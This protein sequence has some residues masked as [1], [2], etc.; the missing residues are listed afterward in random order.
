MHET[1]DQS[2]PDSTT[3]QDPPLRRRQSAVALAGVL[4]F[5]LLVAGIAVVAAR[6]S[7]ASHLPLLPAG[8]LSA[9]GAESPS[10]AEGAVGSAVAPFGPVS[11]RIEGAL[12]TLA[13]H[14]PAYRLDNPGLLSAAT[15]LAAELGLKGTPQDA[16]G[17]WALQDG[18]RSLIVTKAPPGT[19]FYRA[20]SPCS[21]ISNLPA[22]PGGVGCGVGV[23]G[24]GSAGP[25]V[26]APG[27]ASGREA[28]P[29][30]APAGHRAPA[31]AP[32]PNA[33]TTPDPSTT[34]VSGMCPRPPCTDGAC[35]DFCVSPPSPCAYNGSGQ[36]T[37]PIVTLPPRPTDLPSAADAENVA[38]DLVGRLGVPLVHAAVNAVET[39]SGWQVELQPQ[40]DGFPT[41]GYLWSV[42]VG[43]KGVVTQASGELATPSLLGSY[44]LIGAAAGFERLKTGDRVGGGIVPMLGAARPSLVCRQPANLGGA[45]PPPTAPTTASNAG[46]GVPGTATITSGTTT[47]APGTKSQAPAFCQ[48]QV[49]TVT[50]VHLALV[51]V[52]APG[53][54]VMEP[55][56]VF[57]TA[58]RGQIGVPAA[59]DRLV[60][61]APVRP[62]GGVPTPLPNPVR[63]VPAIPVPAPASPDQATTRP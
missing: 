28:A 39:F 44:P 3:L 60:A 55:A 18:S 5:A 48:P 2:W 41:Q 43:S 40:L 22:Q 21:A 7:G 35:P 30:P 10:A 49:I 52:V 12:P 23:I 34:S 32:G 20:N 4:A 46:A 24:S 45:A 47:A 36:S 8:E 27:S 11:Y 57:E 6:G 25:A 14:A 63:P 13:D 59:V 56:Y 37:C 9:A 15:K 31:P 62:P 54:A 58:G 33:A 38:R 61:P 19:W 17:D 51:K 1:T 42:G 26:M 50:G 29:T 53:E 16:N